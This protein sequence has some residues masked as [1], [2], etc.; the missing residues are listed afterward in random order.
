MME[1]IE[2]SE[3]GRSIWNRI[4]KSQAG[5]ITLYLVAIVAANVTIIIFGPTISILNAFLFIG[6]NLTARDKLHDAWSGQNLK[7]N[8]LLLILTGSVIS[9]LFGAGRIAVASFIAFAISESSDAVAY[10]MLRSKHK[11]LQVNGSNV[12]SAGIDSILFPLLAFGWP[13]LIGIMIGQFAAKV[14]GGSIWSIVLHK[15]V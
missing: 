5:I 12:A 6:F 1:E 2:H 13:P 9:F 11:L 3:R 7:R 4:K 8:M 15:K 10:H 14:L